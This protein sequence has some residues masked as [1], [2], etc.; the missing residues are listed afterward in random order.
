MKGGS[1]NPL[2]SY[3]G[4]AELTLFQVAPKFWCPEW[5]FDELI[6]HLNP[7][8]LREQTR[9]EKQLL[10]SSSLQGAVR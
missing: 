1:S 6:I 5:E 7:F 10:R 8:V 2:I 4:M 3:T 9:K